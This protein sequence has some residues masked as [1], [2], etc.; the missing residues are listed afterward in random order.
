MGGGG[1]AAVNTDPPAC[2]AGPA[3]FW[4]AQLCGSFFAIAIEALLGSGPLLGG[5]GGGSRF[6]GASIGAHGLTVRSLRRQI[7]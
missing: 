1:S 5:A 2:G 7:R 3:D 6:H 4:R